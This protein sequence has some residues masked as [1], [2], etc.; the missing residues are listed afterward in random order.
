MP[1]KVIPTVGEPW[2]IRETED[3]AI[4]VQVQKHQ[5]ITCISSY[6]GKESLIGPIKNLQK[7]YHQ[8]KDQPFGMLHT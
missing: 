5:N 3:G 1:G 7:D 8:E 4:S 2:K 6:T